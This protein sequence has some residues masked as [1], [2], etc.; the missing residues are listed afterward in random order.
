LLY[1]N[2]CSHFSLEVKSFLAKHGVVEISR[3]GYSAGLA[4]AAILPLATLKTA[5]KG[6]KFRNVQD[7][8]KSVTAKLNAV[9]LEPNDVFKSFLKHE[10]N[11]FKHAETTF[12]TN[13]TIVASFYVLFPFYTS[14][15]T[16]LPDNAHRLTEY[17]NTDLLSVAITVLRVFSMVYRNIMNTGQKATH[18]RNSSRYAELD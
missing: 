14:V 11:V 3:T 18:F 5:L 16:L 15:E 17:H 2:A 12:T 6:K 10:T 1:D 9:L 8:K 7:I 13:K 4:T